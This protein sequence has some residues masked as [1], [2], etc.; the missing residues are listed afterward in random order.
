MSDEREDREQALV[1]EI[2]QGLGASSRLF[3]MTGAADVQEACSVERYRDR[4]DERIWSE[5]WPDDAGQE[6]PRTVRGEVWTAAI[7]A[8]LDEQRSV[9]IPYR[10]DP[11]YIDAPLVLSSGQRLHVDARAEMRLVPSTN[12]CMV[13]NRSIVSGQDG[14]LTGAVKPDTDI[15][16]T[17][18]IWSTLATSRSESNGNV[19]GRADVDDSCYGAHGTILL[20]NV[21]GIVVRDLTIRQCRPFGI[22]I[23][24]CHDFMIEDI[25][26][27]EQGRD[28]IHVEGP[29]SYGVIR[30]LS[31]VTGDDMVAL[32][33]W[34]WRQYS[35]TFG[36]ITHILVEGIRGAT[37]R[38]PNAG[39][40]PYVPDRSAEVRLL[41]GTK[42]FLGGES[43]DCDIRD[44]VFRDLQNVRTFKVY[45][46][47]NVELGREIDYADPI[48]TLGGLVFGDLRIP[49]PTRE[50]TFQV[51]ANIDGLAIRDVYLGFDPR[52]PE[53]SFYKLMRIGPMS[54]VYKRGEDDPDTWVELFSPDKD[55]TVDNL[56]VARVYAASSERGRSETPVDPAD[57]VEV[58]D[59]QLNPD[60]PRTTPKGGTGQGR[61][62]AHRFG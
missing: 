15:I 48:G 26:F 60:Y 1:R 27:E 32:N 18:G 56:S 58:A 31:G 62:L 13:R 25:R 43:L 49:V 34:D 4:V 61:L 54:A 46:Q 23:G 50:A 42:R 38:P 39:A 57:L 24:N 55:C 35:V 11:Y 51:A 37:Y 30:E 3:E 36:P 45:D 53:A 22:Q 9:S 2:R 52:S 12:T 40:N 47:P 8:A 19:R 10:P 41:A 5:V 20:H 21:Q 44:C 33:A 7:Q 28:G 29:A 16:I 14:P 59:Q 17:G 6:N